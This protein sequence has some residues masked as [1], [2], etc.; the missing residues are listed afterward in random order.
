MALNPLG[1]MLKGSLA[2]K[3]ALTRIEATLILA[4]FEKVVLKVLGRKFEDVFQTVS[5]KD[6]TLIVI[7][8]SSVAVQELRLNEAM[9][10]CELNKILGDKVVRE[11]RV[12][13]G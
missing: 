13:R 2:K 10:I 1:S 4:E 5:F 8:E 6:G 11:I 9:L 3:G 7:C 12:Y